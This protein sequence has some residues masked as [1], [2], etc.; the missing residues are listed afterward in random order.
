MQYLSTWESTAVP[1]KR[2]LHDTAALR[3]L[4]DAFGSKTE[5]LDRP[6]P[7]DETVDSPHDGSSSVMS[8]M[9]SR[10]QSRSFANATTSATRAQ[11]AARSNSAQ[12]GSHGH[13][14]RK[15]AI[16]L[17]LT[18][19]VILL[20]LAGVTLF[21]MSQRTPEEISANPLLNHGRLF[22][23]ISICLA[24]CLVAGAALFQYEVRRAE[25]KNNGPS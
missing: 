17:L 8:T 20:G 18:M 21:L 2:S 3:A 9:P 24:V 5:T 14:F 6:A 12:A 22:S 15:I 13:A 16:P 19:G 11:R 7:R 4:A 1:P 10:K 25:K 23:G